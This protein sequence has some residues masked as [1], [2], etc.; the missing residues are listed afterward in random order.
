MCVCV[1][2][3]KSYFCRCSTEVSCK[4]ATNMGFMNVLVDKTADFVQSTLWSI[5][6]FIIKSKTQFQKKNKLCE[7][8]VTGMLTSY[9]LQLT[10]LIMQELQSKYYGRCYQ[11]HGHPIQ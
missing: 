10:Y 5:T 9:I 3:K 11:S 7:L 1:L 6:L 4:S 8:N 2:K